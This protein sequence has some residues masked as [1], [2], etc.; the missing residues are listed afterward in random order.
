M[1]QEPLRVL[2]ATVEHP[3]RTRFS[4]P[5]AIP[6]QRTTSNRHRHPGPFHC[7]EAFPHPRKASDVILKSKHAPLSSHR[8]RHPRHDSRHGPRRRHHPPPRPPRRRGRHSR[9]LRPYR[10]GEASD[11]A[12]HAG[13][14]LNIQNRFYSTTVPAGRILSQAPAPGSEVRKGW[15]IRVVESLGPQQ[16]TIPDVAGE[17]VR[18]A[19]MDLRRN[20][21]DLGTQVRLDAP[22]DP[23][24]WSSPRPHPPTP[25]STSPASTSS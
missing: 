24:T 18:Q 17:P 16:V 10:P 25:A 14:D 15:Q 21:L 19:T 4:P 1:R 3:S 6:S 23:P 22:G 13:L 7:S 2:G 11:A 20:Q 8:L 12:L 9:P 5:A